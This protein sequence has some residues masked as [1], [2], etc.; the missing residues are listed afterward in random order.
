MNSVH[1]STALLGKMPS[2]S[3]AS[4]LWVNTGTYVVKQPKNTCWRLL[5]QTSLGNL[6]CCFLLGPVICSQPVFRW[7]LAGLFRQIFARPFKFGLNVYLFQK[8]LYEEGLLVV[9][10][11]LA[12]L[13][14]THFLSPQMSS[15]RMETMPM[16]FWWQIV[17]YKQWLVKMISAQIRPTLVCRNHPPVNI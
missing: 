5:L 2:S 10:N 17:Y 11:S 12:S 14:I 8:K 16:W 15:K 6:L 1:I 4:S 7:A 13:V 9:L 3:V